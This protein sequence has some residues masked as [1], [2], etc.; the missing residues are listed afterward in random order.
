MDLTTIEPVIMITLLYGTLCGASL[1]LVDN[2]IGIENI[3]VYGP[4]YYICALCFNFIINSQ[5]IR[6]YNKN[7][8]MSGF[9]LILNTSSITTIILSVFMFMVYVM[10]WYKHFDKLFINN[11]KTIQMKTITV[12]FFFTAVI[13]SL[14]SLNVS[15]SQ[16]C[17]PKYEEGV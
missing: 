11:E 6:M 8:E 15:L 14:I 10:D 4:L 17:V 3:V 9:T 13:T 2:E 1:L 16:Q 12:W 5:Y 7:C